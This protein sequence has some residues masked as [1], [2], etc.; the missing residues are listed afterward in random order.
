MT[1]TNK[2]FDDQ[3]LDHLHALNLI[4]SQHYGVPNETFRCIGN[5]FYN[6]NTDYAVDADPIADYRE[7]R[8]FFT[9]A[10]SGRKSLLEVGFNAGHSALLALMSN[11]DL[12]YTG[13]DICETKYTTA[14]AEYLAQA[15]KSRFTLILGDSREVLP[16]LA[17][18]NKSLLIDVCHIDGDHNEGPVRTDISNVL[19]LAQRNALVILDDLDFPGVAKAYDEYVKLG[20]LHPAKLKGFEFAQRQAVAL[21]VTDNETMKS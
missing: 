6:H 5:L 8:D 18:H 14:C 2:E 9:A 12:V 15:F 10:L 19:R 11:P 13:V 21:L 20:R 4:V 17:T 1:K 7:K 16:R 3:L